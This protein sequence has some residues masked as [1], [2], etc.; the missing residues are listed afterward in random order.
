MPSDRSRPFTVALRA[1]PVVYVCGDDPCFHRFVDAKW[2]FTAAVV[3]DNRLLLAPRLFMRER[4]RLRPILLHELSHLHM[5]Q[6]RGHYTMSIPVWF[7]EGLAS[8]AAGGGGA[9][10]L[11]PTTRLGAPHKRA[12]IFRRSETP[13]VAAAARPESGLSISVF[14]RQSM[15]FLAHLRAQDPQQFVLLLNR[16]QDG[17]DFDEAFASTYHANPNRLAQSSFWL[18]GRSPCRRPSALP[19]T[20]PRVVTQGPTQG[21]NPG[22]ETAGLE[23]ERSKTMLMTTTS[24]LEGHRITR[25][26]G[27]VTGEAIIGANI[28][29][30]FFAKALRDVCVGPSRRVRERLGRRSRNRD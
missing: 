1:P 10:P 19:T 14:Y 8:L 4:E 6:Y 29:S 5:G 30:D 22:L 27:I 3:Y 26:A 23:T 25:Y 13:A 20:Q 21:H 28:F 7:H 24:T 9:D 11:S 2:N 12:N 17:I 18:R 16:L 15:L